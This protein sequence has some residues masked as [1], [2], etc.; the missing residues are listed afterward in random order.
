[1]PPRPV[2][3]ATAALR[4]LRFLA[5]QPG[6]APAAR[7]AAALDLPRSSTYH[8]LR[9]M[10]AEGFVTHYDDDRRWGIGIAAYEV[11]IGY[12]VQEPIARL[13]R[14]PMARLVD[15][16][17]HSAHLVTLHG[18]EVV[19]L[20]EERAPGRP[21]LVT[22]VGVRL[23]A[24]LTASGRAILATLPPAQVRALFPGRAAFVDRTGTGPR[25][26]TALRDLLV[27]TR[28][29]GYATEDDEITPGFASVAAAVDAPTSP[30]RAS[31][32]VTY[33]AG[34]DRAEVDAIVA[35]VTDTAREISR[36][37][38]S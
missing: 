12:A 22:D 8:L 9:A 30:A 29:R 36:R 32:A 17:G 26:P 31:V 37:L 16:V 2:P 25:T 23:P 7:I 38:R 21:P 18:R 10:T 3:A 28:N 4:A 6:P 5:G 11:G 15:T 13:A 1:M 14:I 27:D 34:T 35:A 33:P 24:S 19:Y 20:L